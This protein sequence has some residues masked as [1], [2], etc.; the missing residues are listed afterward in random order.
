MRLIFIC[1]HWHG[2]AKLRMHT[3]I[4]LD[5]MDELTTKLGQ[6]FRDFQDK[7]CSAYETCELPR[8]T[9]KRQ[10]QAAKKAA[11]KGQNDGSGQ[12]AAQPKSASKKVSQETHII[13]FY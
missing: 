1:A 7:V 11:S 9:A 12:N 4:T 13:V 6:A 3:D 2:M 5:I 10:H 8:E